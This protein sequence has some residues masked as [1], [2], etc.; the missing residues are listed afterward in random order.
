MK[1]PGCEN[2]ITMKDIETRVDGPHDGYAF[3]EVEVFCPKCEKTFFNRVR[4]EDL[5]DAE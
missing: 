1:C 5:I 3:I 2:I 4:P